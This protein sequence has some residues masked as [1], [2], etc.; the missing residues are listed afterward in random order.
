MEQQPERS[1]TTLE[2]IQIAS[3]ERSLTNQTPSNVNPIQFDTI[4]SKAKDFA[5][6][7]ITM[8]TASR[9]QIL[10]LRKIEEAVMWAIKGVV[11]N[12]K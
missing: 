3:I 10:A 11:L 6:A 8:S 5:R 12:T 4:R 7:V 2:A 1:I 9:E